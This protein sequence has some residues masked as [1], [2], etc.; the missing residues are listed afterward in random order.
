[1]KW[2]LFLRM[3]IAKTRGNRHWWVRTAD[4]HIIHQWLALHVVENKG[5]DE[6]LQLIVGPVML[7]LAARLGGGA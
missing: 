1:M 5:G 6:I 2:R 3:N 7:C 4:G